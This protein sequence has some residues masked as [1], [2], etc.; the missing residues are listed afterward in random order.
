LVYNLGAKTFG[1]QD[2][3]A[4]WLATENQ[5]LGGRKPKELFD[6]SFGIGLLKDELI[7]IEHGVI[8]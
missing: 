3:F 7:R 8:T 5:A 1:N 6:T 4:R 2:K